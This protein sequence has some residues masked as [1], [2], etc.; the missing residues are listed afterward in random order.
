V[1]SA[2]SQN[3][4]DLGFF[5]SLAG[6]IDRGSKVGGF[7]LPFFFVFVLGRWVGVAAAFFIRLKSNDLHLKF[8]YSVHFVCVVFKA[9]TAWNQTAFDALSLAISLPFPI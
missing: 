6:E 8:K 4:S 1:D 2:L 5:P 3:R 9:L 7:L